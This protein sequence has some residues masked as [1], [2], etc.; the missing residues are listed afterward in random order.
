MHRPSPI[1]SRLAWL[2]VAVASAAL[3]LAGGGGCVRGVSHSSVSSDGGEAAGAR[4]DAATT[5]ERVAAL[6]GEF[7]AMGPGVSP[8]E[9]ALVADVAVRYSERLA[10][11]YGMVRPVEL[12]NVLVNLRLRRGGLCYQM[13]E[14]M[15]AELQELPLRTLELHRAI[16]WRG[17][18]WN[19]HNTVV[20]AAA[21]APFESGV[22]LDAW[23]NGGRLRWAPVRM[24]HY[25][26][27]FKPAPPPRLGSILAARP[28]ADEPYEA[29]PAAD[30]TGSGGG[31]AVAEAD[32]A[33]SP[34][35]EAGEAVPAAA[36]VEAPETAPP[37]AD[38]ETPPDGVD[39]GP[40][41]FSSDTSRDP[42]DPQPP[43]PAR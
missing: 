16:A 33:E 13:A 5:D 12:H 28:D 1:P 6:A 35:H 11:S 23:R 34:Q 8:D 10:E 19:E 15:L 29:V 25:P 26:W 42:Q 40:S 36:T 30:G 18:L 22:V 24:D 20:V 31:D 39:A 14:C 21:G 37:A 17:D 9:A 4:L 43:S 38:D 3:S 41:L 7:R 27:Q 32:A 2:V